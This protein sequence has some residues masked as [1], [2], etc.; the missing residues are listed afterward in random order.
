VAEKVF[1]PSYINLFKSGKFEERIYKLNDL[2]NPCVLCPR[3]CGANREEDEKGYCRTGK[4]ALVASYC[5]HR[6][7]EPIISGFNGSGTVFFANCNLSCVFC[8]NYEISQNWK[9]NFVKA[10]KEELAEI[11]LEL[12]S[13][14]VHNINWVSPSHIVPQAV[15]ALF[16][17]AEKGLSIPVVYNSNG[18]DSAQTLKL[19]DGIV[20]IYMP[21]FKYFDEKAAK[22]LSDALNYPHFAKQAIKEMWRQVGKLIV[23]ENGVALRGLLVR[24]LVL[25]N[26]L[27]QSE[28]VIKYLAEEVSPDIAISLM[29]QYYPAHKAPFDKR[30]N[31][32]I[33]A[34]EYQKAL[35]A[36]D[37]SKI[38]EGYVQEISSH[39][40]YRP[41]FSKNGNPF[42]G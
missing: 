29:S 35:D 1:T 16:I 41:D 10:T 33:T 21:D 19:L 27:S 40:H 3:M 34:K 22:E 9:E 8:Q 2:L 18:Y 26:N 7:E 23:D 12:Q 38:S 42:E 30:I 11:Y 6:G 37:E 5:V 13:M 31:R 20:D 28:Q 24:H 14:K 17:A 4:K 36:L 39:L 25:P 15:E 32:P